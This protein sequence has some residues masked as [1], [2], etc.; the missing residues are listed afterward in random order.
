MRNALLVL[1]LA[2]GLA[3]CEDKYQ[4][5]YDAGFAAGYAQASAEGERKL[6][7]LRDELES[8]KR[9]AAISAYSSQAAYSSVV[10]TVCGGNGLNL[11]GKHYAPGKTG[12]V[13]A[14]SDGTVQRY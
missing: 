4:T 5:G 11:N 13:R 7:G 3:G 9:Q 6:A 12:C 2:L 8:A 14:M 10:T 1:T